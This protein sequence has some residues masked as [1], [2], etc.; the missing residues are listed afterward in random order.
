MNNNQLQLVTFEQAKRLKEAG[1]DWE[2]IS[3]YSTKKRNAG[4]T[5]YSGLPINHNSSRFDE[6]ATV[7]APAVALALKWCRDVKWWGYEVRQSTIGASEWT[8]HIMG[9]EFNLGWFDTYEAAESALL[10]ELL[11]LIE[12]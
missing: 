10:D 5:Y 9:M 6:D 7:C 11:K 3:Y 8:A 2:N 1:F 4:L 12:E